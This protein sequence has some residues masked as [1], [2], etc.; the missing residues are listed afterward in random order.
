MQTNLMHI[1]YADDNTND[2][3]MIEEAVT[4]ITHL[5]ITTNSNGKDFID[6]INNLPVPGLII[7]NADLPSFNGA[8]CVKAIRSMPR[9]N[10]V[11][12]IVFKANVQ[13]TNLVECK[14]AGADYTQRKPANFGEILRFVY[15]ISLGKYDNVNHQYNH[16]MMSKCA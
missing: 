9:F 3:E 7:F 13:H 11:P 10:N 6:S 15:N 2:L 1:L 12:I 4:K 5:S 16:Q 8:N 14:E